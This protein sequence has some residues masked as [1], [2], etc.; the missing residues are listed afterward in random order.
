VDRV[1]HSRFV[2]GQQ[3]RRTRKSSVR[4]EQHPL[5]RSDDHRLDRGIIDLDNRITDHRVEPNPAD[6]SPADYARHYRSA[7]GARRLA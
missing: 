1:S 3:H 7:P 5:D 4:V 2:G 6:G